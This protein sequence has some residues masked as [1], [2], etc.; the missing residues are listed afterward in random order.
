[1]A[2]KKEQRIQ[3]ASDVIA[4]LKAKRFRAKQRVYAKLD[5]SAYARRSQLEDEAGW[6]GDV[7]AQEIVRAAKSCA[8]CARGGI[9]LAAIDRFNDLQVGPSTRSIEG[10]AE[11]GGEE[12]DEEYINRW[13]TPG[14]L[15]E[16]EAAFEGWKPQ[17]DDDQW[18]YS[19]Y[20]D[21][22][23]WRKAYPNATDRMD[24]VMRGLIAGDGKF[25]ITRIPRPRKTPISQLIK[26]QPRT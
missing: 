10:V 5:K 23:P 25:D 26:R 22:R 24:A 18:G 6:G 3:I 12:G 19:G 15:R 2:S 11:C 14:Q 16:M 7:S 13:F 1:M 21:G 17:E 9:V 4:Q 20:G 8:V